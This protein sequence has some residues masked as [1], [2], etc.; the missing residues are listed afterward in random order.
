MDKQKKRAKELRF[1]FIVK[2]IRK[3]N[4]PSFHISLFLTSPIF[5]SSVLRIFDACS[6]RAAKVPRPDTF[7]PFH[8][9][10]RAATCA[11]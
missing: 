1:I 2:R 4:L 3:L 5:G 6:D 7:I 10:W 9:R 8:M 11:R